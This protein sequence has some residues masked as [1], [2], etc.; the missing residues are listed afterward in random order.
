MSGTGI[1]GSLAAHLQSTT[2]TVS[3]WLPLSLY[4]VLSAVGIGLVVAAIIRRRRGR[5]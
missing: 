5:K 1:Q 4:V 3:A 2:D